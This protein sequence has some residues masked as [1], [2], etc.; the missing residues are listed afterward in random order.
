MPVKPPDSANSFDT[1]QNS[2]WR[3]CTICGGTGAR[4]II[5]FDSG[6]VAPTVGETITGATS[7]DT[8]VVVVAYLRSGTYA[9]GDAAGVM[10]LSSPTGYERENYTIFQNDENINGSTSGDNMATVTGN[11]SVVFNGVLYPQTDMI[12]Y[13][14]KWYCSD[15]FVWRYKL[16]WEQDN[17]YRPSMESKRSYD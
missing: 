2:E 16:E 4:A 12:E 17:T 1:A 11:P 14:G 15:H 7:G 13:K 3:A 8:G 9:G 10:E 6:S 5:Y